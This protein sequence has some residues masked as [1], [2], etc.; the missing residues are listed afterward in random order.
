MTSFEGFPEAGIA[1]LR[2]LA[3]NN[4]RAWFKQNQAVYKN[5]LEGPG[6][7]F[8]SAMEAELMRRFS[9]PFTG[10]VF[11]LHRDLRFSKD[12]TP[13]NCHLRMAFFPEAGMTQGLGF[14]FSLETTALILGGGAMGFSK[15]GLSAFRQAVSEDSGGKEIAALVDALVTKGFRLEA[16]ELKR[17]PAGFDADSPREALLRRKSLTL[18]RDL[19]GHDVLDDRAAV[20]YCAE[21]FAQLH[22]LCS[23]L[24]RFL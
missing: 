18:W 24:G 21:V 17:V 6:R 1:F 16:P 4:D 14:Y 20:A 13:Y 23:L 15:S 8:L 12:K 5:S 10:K 2:D 22:P 19:E 3:A 7:R 11:R 9:E